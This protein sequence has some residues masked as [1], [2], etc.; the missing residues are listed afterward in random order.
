MLDVYTVTDARV[1]FVTYLVYKKSRARLLSVNLTDLH[2]EAEAEATITISEH[3]VQSSHYII[4]GYSC[5]KRYKLSKLNLSS[6][7]SSFFMFCVDGFFQLLS[8]FK[9]RERKKEER[10]K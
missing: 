6:S 8:L 9:I 7:F 3:N 1:V 4:F 10:H 2:R 5:F